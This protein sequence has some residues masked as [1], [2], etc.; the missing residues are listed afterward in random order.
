MSCALAA[1]AL[2]QES[3]PLEQT[4]ARTQAEQTILRIEEGLRER[5]DDGTLQ[6]Y[7][8]M[9]QAQAG[10][11]D[12]SLEWLKRVAARRMGF[13]PTAAADSIRLWN[14]PAFQQ[15]LTEIAAN[16]PKVL[17]AREAF[18][19]PDARFVPEGIAYD[20]KGKRHFIGSVA[21]RRI[22]ERTRAGKFVD[23]SGTADGSQVRPGIARRRGAR[24][25]L[26]RV[27]QWILETSGRSSGERALR[28]RPEE[29]RAQVALLGP[30]S[31]QSQRRR[32]RREWR[33]G[34]D[35]FG[36]G[37]RLPARRGERRSA[38]HRSAARSF[39]PNGVVF[40][41]DDKRIYVA[42]A[43][44]VASVD[45][46]SG[47]LERLSQPDDIA[48]GAIDGLYFYDGDLIGVQNVICPGRVV[49]LDLDA[50]GKQLQ[51][52]TVLQAYHPVL[53]E[54]TTG[55]IVGKTLHVIGNSSVA[56]I[57]PDGALREAETMQPAVILA[58][59]LSR[60]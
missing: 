27:D 43:T 57:Q 41:P 45:L 10:H 55:A 18:R 46:A 28:L 30:G 44:G 37:E 35:R 42:A 47:A 50:D 48:T 17:G 38:V 11:P 25:S 40:A 56:R 49:R 29:P 24:A 39:L 21:Q 20:P 34:G 60:R 54:P 33:R 31:G 1:I 23:F 5:P 53:D 36:R 58:V 13:H 8:A 52:L 12:K 2:A 32:R 26:C 7:M 14:D 6:Y 22:L 16:E 59:P 19:L 9:F 15:V 3:E 4:A 51:G